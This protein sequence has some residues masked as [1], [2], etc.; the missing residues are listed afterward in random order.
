[1][2][3]RGQVGKSGS[4]ANLAASMRTLSAAD[5]GGAAG[6]A[7]GS[8]ALSDTHTPLP[9]CPPDR[10]AQRFMHTVATEVELSMSQYVPP[11]HRAE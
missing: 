3:G 5:R 2:F 4:N 10:F 7:G 9:L 6:G 11:P 8:G 1:M